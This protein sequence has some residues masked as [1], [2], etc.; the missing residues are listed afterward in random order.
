M[1]GRLVWVGG[2]VGRRVGKQAAGRASRAVG[3]GV[4]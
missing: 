3:I 4:G 2:S 1:V